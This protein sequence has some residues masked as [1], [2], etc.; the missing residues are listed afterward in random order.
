MTPF[1]QAEVMVAWLAFEVL[2][3]YA[4]ENSVVAKIL[5]NRSDSSPLKKIILE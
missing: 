3:T 4:V 1:D 2:V 5:P